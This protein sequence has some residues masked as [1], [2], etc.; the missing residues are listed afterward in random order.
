MTLEELRAEID[1]VDDALAAL[2]ARRMDLAAQVAAIKRETGAPVFQPARE[3]AILERLGGQAETK[4]LPALQTVYEAIFRAS[5]EY[6]EG[7]I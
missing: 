6:Q 4:Y 7:L 2:L 5:R 3:K 1:A